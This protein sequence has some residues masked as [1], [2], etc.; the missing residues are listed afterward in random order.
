MIACNRCFDEEKKPSY[1][2][3]LDINYSNEPIV[4]HLCED[5]IGH[6]FDELRLDKSKIPA[7]W[8]GEMVR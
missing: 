4:F 1:I 6:L 2:L 7:K 3:T 5:C 8:E